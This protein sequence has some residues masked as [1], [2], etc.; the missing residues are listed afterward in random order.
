MITM[1]LKGKALCDGSPECT[2][3]GAPHAEGEIQLCPAPKVKFRAGRPE[4][5]NRETYLG[6]WMADWFQELG[7]T[8]LYEDARKRFGL[9]PGCEGCK[10]RRRW[11]NVVHRWVKRKKLSG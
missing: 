4:Q 5:I 2:T 7:A 9:P 1:K 3:C 6:D 11:I 10:T 8:D